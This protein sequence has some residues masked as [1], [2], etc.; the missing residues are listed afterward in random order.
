ME[1][2]H[3]SGDRKRRPRILRR[4]VKKDDSTSYDTSREETSTPQKVREAIEPEGEQE[5]LRKSE[6]CLHDETI[7][8]AS[9]QDA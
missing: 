8:R 4:I 5:R 7:A 6:E 2:E 1:R 3:S 9:G